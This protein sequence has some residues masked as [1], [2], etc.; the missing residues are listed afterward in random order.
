M[1][2][3]A[4]TPAIIR[5]K[6]VWWHNSYTIYK[7]YTSQF[8]I[9][10]LINNVNISFKKLLNAKLLQLI[11]GKNLNLCFFFQET[12]KFLYNSDSLRFSN[13]RLQTL[14]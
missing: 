6:N 4:T 13:L 5:I 10:Y 14:A 3:K 7:Q 2:F 11:L 8:C 9:L 12:E 1:H